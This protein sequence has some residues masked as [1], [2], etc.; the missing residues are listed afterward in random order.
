M[1]APIATIDGITVEIQPGDTILTAAKRAGINIPTLCYHDDLPIEG[2]CRVCMVRSA[3]EDR[4]YAACHTPLTSG[5]AIVANDKNLNQ[6]RGDVLSLI[7]STHPPDKFEP[8]AEGDEVEQLMVRFNL[9]GPRFGYHGFDADI[10]ATHP[11][12]RFD[13]T[14]CITCRR[15]LNAC[16]AIQ[17]QFVYGIEGRGIATKLIYGPTENFGDSECTACGACVDRCP[18][19]AITDRDRIENIEAE[20][21][22]E[23]VCGYCGVG[24]RLEVETRDNHVLRVNPAANAEV[25]DG[26]LCAKGRYAHGYHDHADRLTQPLLRVGNRWKTIAWDEAIALAA[27]RM[28]EIQAEHGPESV[29]AITSSRSTNEACYLLQKLFRTALGSNNVDCCARVCHSS[30]ALGLKTVTGT[31]AASASYEDIERARCIVI[32]GA[33]PTEA[34]PVVGARLKQAALRGVPLVVIDPRA[35]EL[36]G[37]ANCFLQIRPGTNV[38]LFNAIGKILVEENLFNAD[39]VRERLEGFDDYKKFIAGL[40]IEEA[41]QITGVRAE[42]IVA[43][44]RLIAS[45]SPALFVSGLGLSEQSQGT[46]SVMTYAALGMLTGSIG[47]P[48]AGMLPLRGQNNVQG[49]ADVGSAPNLLPGYLA[50]ND[51]ETRARLT[52]L[53]GQAPPLE[54]GLT[55]PQMFESG[56]KTHVRALW[57]QGEDI[58][59]SES[60]QQQV[61]AAL[62]SME[63]IVVQDIFPCETG[64]FAHLILP[65]AGALENDGTFTNGER[66]IQRVRP[67]GDAPGEARQDWIVVRDIAREMGCDWNYNSPAEVMDELA[68]AAPKTFGGVSYDRLGENGIQ[69]PCPEP[70]HPGTTTIHADAF[71]RGKG[72]LVTIDYAPSPEQADGGYPFVL[73]TGRVLQQYNVGTMTRRSPHRELHS[74]DWLEIHPEDAAVKQ[75]KNGDRIRVESRWGASEVPARLTTR[76]APGTLFLSFHYPESHA[77]LLVGPHVDP[78]SKCPDYKVTAVRIG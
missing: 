26:H 67:V 8:N 46:A 3:N 35:I 20:N 45:H 11:Y 37:Y 65:S 30:T 61:H 4:H 29:A 1:T 43:A 40:S 74:T 10:D 21:A 31:A 25:N 47:R 49:S 48:G 13:P 2:G 60:N 57:V 59:Q 15:C 7:L 52:K 58:A 42:K 16:E 19:G 14:I 63:F 23:T 72:Q 51:T 22:T 66:R 27:K 24:C 54:A 28:K 73:V 36:A 68:Q 41:A 34:H 77:N 18:T 38:A 71:I 12:L 50:L 64:R 56:D 76:V 39:Y 17:G 62:E 78:L 53:W 69:W 75:I 55:I 32:A 44:A 6:L 70:G 33:N 9:A 5:M